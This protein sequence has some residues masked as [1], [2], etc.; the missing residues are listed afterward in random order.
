MISAFGT[1]KIRK[2]CPLVDG[3]GV[4]ALADAAAAVGARRFVLNVPWRA[5]PAPSSGA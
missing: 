1:Y 5:W 2:D 3:E 4:I